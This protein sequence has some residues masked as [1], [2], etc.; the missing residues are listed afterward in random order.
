MKT[1]ALVKDINGFWKVYQPLLIRYGVGVELLDV[2]QS[3]EQA[4]LISSDYD[5]FIWRTKHTPSRRN[6][7]RR[8]IYFMEIER[9]VPTFPEWKTFWHYDD[10]IS[11]FYIFNRLRIPTPATHIF[12]NRE[13]ALA[14]CKNTDYPL[15]YKSSHGAG[16]ANVGLLQ[17]KRQ[18]KAY[19]KKAFGSG[20]KT[21]FKSEIQKDYVYFQEFIA[22]NSGDFRLICLGTDIISGFFRHNRKDSPFASGSGAF[23]VSE[24]PMELLNFTAE[25]HQRCQYDIMSYDI[26]RDQQNQWVI[27][28]MSVIYGDLT[29]TVYDQAPVYRKSNGNQWEL[30]SPELNRHEQFIQFLLKKWSLV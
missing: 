14:F 10:K 3:A 21:Y 23:D 25:I 22:G 16:S 17:S 26:I 20:I 24:L 4:R 27:T 29:H 18:A 13:D 12:F 2:F 8:L 28:E 5:G 11:Q 30:I 9:S 1:I 6:L 15:I 7:A 19:V